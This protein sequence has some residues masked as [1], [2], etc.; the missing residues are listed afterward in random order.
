[1]RIARIKDP[2]MSLKRQTKR[3]VVKRRAEMMIT[4]LRVYEASI[5]YMFK[6]YED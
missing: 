4:L 1:M 3:R 5:A 6:D 2:V